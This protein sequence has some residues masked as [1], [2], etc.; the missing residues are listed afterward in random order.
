MRAKRILIGGS[1]SVGKSTVAKQLSFQ[2]AC[3]HFQLDKMRKESKNAVFSSLDGTDIWDSDTCSLVSILKAMSEASKPLIQNW[4]N[5]I[6]NGILEG[7]GIE[8]ST[9]AK[10]G[11]LETTGIVYLIETELERIHNTLHDQSE[12]YRSLSP[13]RQEQVVAMNSEYSAYLRQ[14]AEIAGHPWEWSQP[15]D[16]LQERILKVIA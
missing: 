11:N 12:R 8:P 1:S 3:E 10:V 2:L 13:E 9:L 4:C 14:E 15:W 7:E 16:T 6:Q 5:K